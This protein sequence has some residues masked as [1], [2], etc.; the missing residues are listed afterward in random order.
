MYCVY[1]KQEGDP[2]WKWLWGAAMV[3][4]TKKMV[5]GARFSR[6][7]REFRVR[8]FDIVWWRGWLWPS[9]APACVCLYVFVFV[10][11]KE[12]GRAHTEQKK[13]ENNAKQ[14]FPIAFQLP[15]NSLWVFEFAFESA[16]VYVYSF[17][18]LNYI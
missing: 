8:K 11:P 3:V 2:R 18:L 9:Y 17:S 10:E 14:S 4:E 7:L 1:V 12:N 15:A 6:I 13:E 16:F 5:A